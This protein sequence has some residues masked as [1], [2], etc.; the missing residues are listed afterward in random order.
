MRRISTHILDIVHGKPASDIS[1]RLEKRCTPEDWRVLNT[2]RSDLNG[3]CAQLLPEGEDLSAGMYR[4]VFDTGIYYA[5]QNIEALYPVVEVTF[6]A[7]EGDSHFHIPLL[8]S[9]N[10]YTTYRGS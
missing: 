8:L 10:G 7:A 9:P 5:Q 1:V 4:L 2:A 6:R 3:R